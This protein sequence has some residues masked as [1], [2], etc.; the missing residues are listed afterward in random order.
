MLALAAG[1]AIL[2][3]LM[4]GLFVPLEAWAPHSPRTSSAT[5][6]LA[7]AG[8]FTFNT[9]LMQ[10]LGV[11]V[12]DALAQPV[13]APH[14]ARFAAAFVLSEVAGYWLHR[15]MHRVPALWKLHSVH[16]APTELD[17]LTGWRQ[18]PLDFLL[19]GLAVALPG[20]LLGAQLSELASVVA[21]RKAWTAFLHSNV[22]LRFGALEHIIATPAF[23]RVHHSA[24]PADFDRNF[25]GTLP[26]LDVLFGTWR[27]PHLPTAV[28]FVVNS[29]A[30]ATSA[31][32]AVAAGR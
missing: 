23:H 26:A 12:L 25:A 27:T 20:V 14:P 1:T 9:F 16:H 4:A 32:G 10:W 13:T 29:S 3:L 18:H 28:G 6:K 7:A 17:W 11:P 8:I 21:L 15:A 19:H 31:R 24:D 22:T 2:L 30:D 5:Q